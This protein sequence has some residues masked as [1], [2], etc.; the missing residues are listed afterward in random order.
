[1]I[2]LLGWLTVST[3]FVYSAA[4]AASVATQGNGNNPADQK[5]DPF[6]NTTEEKTEN[7]IASLSEEFIHDHAFTELKQIR[8]K[9]GKGSCKDE[10]MYI[11]FHGE[12]LCPPPNN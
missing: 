8:T 1:M 3:P 10:K 5:E 2:C 9:Y 11:A 7:S 12:L 4:K 6:S